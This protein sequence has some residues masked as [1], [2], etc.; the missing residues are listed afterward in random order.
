MDSSNSLFSLIDMR[1]FSNLWFWLALAVLWSSA[2]H[3]VLGIPYDMVTRARRYGGQSQADLDDLARIHVTRMLGT[4]RASGQWL[5]GLVCF[6]L[7][8]LALLGFVYDIETAQAMFLLGFPMALVSLLSLSTARRIEADQ[9][10]GEA[11][12]QRLSRMRF[13]VQ[14]TGILSIFVTSLWGMYQNLSM[15]ILGG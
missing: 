4:A 6:A 5:L 12:C 8:A 2:T 11:L 10:Q 7:T 14:V 15:S 13:Y 9:A 3:W 1:S